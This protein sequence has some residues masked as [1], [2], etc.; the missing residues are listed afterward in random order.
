MQNVEVPVQENVVVLEREVAL[1]ANV[2]QRGDTLGQLRLAVR[3]DET[4]DALE[5]FLGRV[6][7]RDLG[8]RRGAQVDLLEQRV[9]GAAD[10]GRGQASVAAD[11]LHAALCH[12]GRVERVVLV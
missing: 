3:G 1:L 11:R 8:H 9:H 5:L 4:A 2:R 6:R 12:P 10:L 7:I